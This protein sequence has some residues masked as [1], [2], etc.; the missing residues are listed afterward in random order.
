MARL[1]LFLFV[2]SLILVSA[3]GAEE[4]MLISNQNGH[5]VELV[6]LSTLKSLAVTPVGQ[7]PLTVFVTHNRRYGLVAS[8]AFTT[9]GGDVSVLDLNA[10]GMPVVAT[11]SRNSRPYGVAATPDSKLALVTRMNGS[12]P[13][14]QLVDLTATPPVDL[15]QP[16]VIP[17][18]RSAYGVAVSPDNRTAYVLD[19]SGT[20]LTVFD[21]TVSPPAVVKQLGTNKSAIFL[22]LS[23]DGRR[24]VIASIA[25]PAQAGVW[26]TESVI[27]VKTGNVA[28]GSNPGAIPAFDPGNTYAVLAAAAGK[29]VHA[30]DAHSVPPAALGTVLSVGSDLRGI[31]V[32][33]DGLAAWAAARSGN[34]LVEVDMSNP[35][36]PI[37]TGRTLSVASGPNS[38]F[39]FGEVHAHGI[40]SLGT[41]YPI[42]VSSPPNAGKAYILAASF[43]SRPG[44]PLGTRTVPLNLDNLFTLSQLVPSIFQNFQG[45]LNA[46]GQAVAS[47]AIPGVPALQGFS[48]VVAGVIV[49]PASPMGIGTVTNAEHIVLQ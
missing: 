30:I 28:V 45:V 21:L 12:T 44:F 24:L 13:E 39:T 22:T 34:Q 25:T 2:A 42:Q 10:P 47:L 16:I 23:N 9:N 48:F 14:L 6:D 38:L 17:N 36:Q 29:S 20:T 1:A 43:S 49:D 18:G 32:T 3:I 46:N 33:T 31:T 15:G 11:V 41:T 37:K 19:F 26:N 35:R 4:R 8:T 7:Q 40:P 5:S 27:P